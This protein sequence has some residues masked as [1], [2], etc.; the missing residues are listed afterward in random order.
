MNK[1]LWLDKEYIQM[2]NSLEQDITTEVL[3][4]GGGISGILC[5]YEL[6][7]RNIDYVIVEKDIIGSGT[8]KDTTAFITAQHEHLYKDLIKMH[9]FDKAKEYLHLNLQAVKKY[10]DLSKKYDFD[11]EDCIST[12]YT[13]DNKEQLLKEDSVLKKLRFSNYIK[14]QYRYYD[15]E[16]CCLSYLNQ[17]ILNPYK[18][19]KELSKEL[20]IFEKTEVQIL[21]RNEAFLK[22]G[23]K[24]K[25]KYAIICTHYP[26][27]NISNLMF[28]KLNQTR[29]YVVVVNK[30]K[31]KHTYCS[32]DKDGWYFRSY[33]DYFLI[34]GNDR[35]TKVE[36]KEEFIKKVCK[37]LKI[38]EED[39]IYSWSGQDCMTV[40]KVPYIGRFSLFKRNH[41]VITGFNLW[42]FT[43]AMVASDIIANMIEKKKVP[44]FTKLNR[45][46][47][48]KQLFINIITS[49]KNLINFKKVR[50]T[51]LGCALKYNKYEK[52]WECPCHGSRYNHSKKVIDS[53]AKIDIRENK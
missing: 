25:F 52:T 1:S 36:C 18:L 41:F 42:G 30:N 32:I 15:K 43:W 12:L 33:N 46:C 2:F 48:R 29:S 14:K 37:A 39:I 28:M 26:L 40:D 38:K 45:F 23:K 8:S 31:I 19:I 34:G 5:G 50:C 3:I 17:G 21:K 35:N 47:I 49:I 20:N 27:N 7:K 44:T 24:I 10:K 22:N 13:L 53:P 6:S 4:I 9:G 16:I 51:H 11:Y